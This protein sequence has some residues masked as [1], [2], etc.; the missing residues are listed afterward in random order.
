MAIVISE[1]ASKKLTH[2]TVSIFKIPIN[3]NDI[4]L[5]IYGDKDNYKVLPNIGEKT[6]GGI[7]CSRRRIVNSITLSSL[8]D[9]ALRKISSNDSTYSA[10]GIVDDIYVY[11]N[12]ADIMETEDPCLSQFKQFLIDQEA[13]D[14]KIVEVLDPYRDQNLLSSDAAYAYTRA[15]GSIDF[16]DTKKKKWISE[17]SFDNIELEVRV[18]K[19]KPAEIGSKISNRYGGKGVISEIL[20][21]DQMPTTETGE[22]ADVCLNPLGILGRMNISALYE[23]EI[24][25]LSRSIRRA[26]E[27]EDYETKK[28]KLL[29]FYGMLNFDERLSIE[30]EIENLSEEDAHEFVD[31][32][33][34]S[35]FPIHMAPF[36]GNIDYEVFA[37]VM[38]ASL[39]HTTKFVGIEQPLIFGNMYFIKL[40][41]EPSSKMSVR[42][43]GQINQ[44]G[45]PNKANRNFKQGLSPYS[46]TPVRMGEQELM[47]LL[48]VKDNKAVFKM[49]DYHSSNKEGRNILNGTL[50]TRNLNEPIVVKDS[51]YSTVKELLA[52]YMSTLG[53][54]LVQ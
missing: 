3:T 20:P 6:K 50:L 45:V 27:N 51:S 17:N 13:F 9:E 42:S 24:N 19:H 7:L 34:R 4:L 48:L 32:F 36:F 43:C 26:Y 15:R 10:D 30:E 8:N 40:K 52:A 2:S 54:K 18:I 29:G 41:H 28:D 23:L 35:G 16:K 44:K 22:H 53:I 39:S 1:S 31:E 25:S 11:C 5:N 46:S 21:D 14:K 38:K 12:R 47:N 49:L 37:E 33:Y